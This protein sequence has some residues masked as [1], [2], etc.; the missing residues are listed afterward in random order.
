MALAQDLLNEL[1]QEASVIRRFLE[2]VPFDK[3]V[4][5]PDE[6]SETLGR[7]AVHVAEILA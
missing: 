4:Y 7:L 1:K 2:R 5:R 6:K 3:L